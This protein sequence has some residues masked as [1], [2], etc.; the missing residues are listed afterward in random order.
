M[1]DYVPNVT[2]VSS[3]RES[4]HNSGKFQ[5]PVSIL[6]LS[7]AYREAGQ[8][9]FRNLNDSCQDTARSQGEVGGLREMCDQCPR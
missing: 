6:V 5:I 4:N 3:G 1:K 7:F 9:I 8:H 2:S